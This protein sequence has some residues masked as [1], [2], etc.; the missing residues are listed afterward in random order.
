MILKIGNQ[1][2]V[3]TMRTTESVAHVGERETTQWEYRPENN[4]KGVVVSSSQAKISGKS[5]KSIDSQ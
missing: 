5:R 2:L 4:Q 1:E 3:F